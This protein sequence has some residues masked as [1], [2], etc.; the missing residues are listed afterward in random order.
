MVVHESDMVPAETHFLAGSDLGTL[1]KPV[2]V[3]F[4]VA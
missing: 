4:V 2:T 1:A 3:A